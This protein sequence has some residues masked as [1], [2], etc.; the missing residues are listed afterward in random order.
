MK[1]GKFIIFGIGVICGYKYHDKIENKINNISG[2][3]A[4]R[5]RYKAA[6]VIKN[7]I[8]KALY[9]EDGKKT[10]GYCYDRKCYNPNCRTK[11]RYKDED[12]S[13]V[14]TQDK[15]N[16]YINFTSSEEAMDMVEFIIERI[17]MYGVCSRAEILTHLGFE[18]CFADNRSGFTAPSFSI[19]FDGEFYKL[20]INNFENFKYD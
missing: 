12:Y 5:I 19:D 8:N 3:I 4:E 13:G 9:L 1:I 20:E 16:V 15:S 7:A 18:S 2:K 10:N 14:F 6:D 11:T 17:H